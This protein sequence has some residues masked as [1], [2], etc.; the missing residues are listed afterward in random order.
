MD[1]EE[2]DK[3]IRERL[4]KEHGE[5][6]RIQRHEAPDWFGNGCLVSFEVPKSASEEVPI[7]RAAFFRNDNG[8]PVLAKDILVKDSTGNY[9]TLSWSL[10][11]WARS[12]DR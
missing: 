1:D 12:Q 2:I 9:A 11:G 7:V 3:S 5:I 4:M 8:N 6:V 10:R